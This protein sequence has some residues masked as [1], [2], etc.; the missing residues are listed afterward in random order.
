M[1]ENMAPSIAM[2]GNGSDVVVWAEPD[3]GQVLGQLFDSAGAETGGV[4]QINTE[5]N[6]TINSNYWQPNYPAGAMDAAG[7]FVVTWTQQ[8]S[9]SS[10]DQYKAQLR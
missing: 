5:L 7:A 1:T 6:P 4:F 10:N 9:S 3:T 2:T 8:N